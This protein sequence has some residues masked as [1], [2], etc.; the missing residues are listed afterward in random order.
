MH[1]DL[2]SLTTEEQPQLGVERVATFSD[3]VFAIA[4][5]LLVL[6]IEIPDIPQDQVSTALPNV[7]TDQWHSFFSFALSFVIIGLYWMSHHRHFEHIVRH[8]GTLLWLNLLFLLSICFLPFPT[9]LLGSYGGHYLPVVIYAGT[10]IAIGLFNTALW[11]YAWRGHRLV[12]STLDLREARKGSEL[13]LVPAAIFALSIPIAL[14]SPGYGEASWA[15]IIPAQA[16]VGRLA[17]RRDSEEPQARA[18]T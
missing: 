7:I 3:A 2:D 16:L 17:H 15:L 13:M 18:T 14:V 9:G 10:N 4:M 1:E 11:T 6:T 8:D 5:T 12:R